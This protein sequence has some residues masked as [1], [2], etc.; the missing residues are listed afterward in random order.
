MT[1]ERVSF[2]SFP[3]PGIPSIDC[4]NPQHVLIFKL[5]DFQLHFDR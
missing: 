4:T 2:F 5:I 1:T 3:S